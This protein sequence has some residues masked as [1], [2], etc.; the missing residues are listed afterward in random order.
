MSFSS[1]RYGTLDQLFEMELMANGF[2]SA[3]GGNNP[4]SLSYSPE[5]ASLLATG[6]YN[7]TG[8]AR[9]GST[10]LSSAVNGVFHHHQHHHHH[11][12]P[13]SNTASHHSLLTTNN[14]PPT[15]APSPYSPAAA[16]YFTATN[17]GNN[18]N[19]NNSRGM[20]P[21]GSAPSTSAAAAAA[22]NTA[23][24]QMAAVAFEPIPIRQQQQQQ[25]QAASRQQRQ[26]NDHDRNPLEEFLMMGN[27]SFM[28]P[29]SVAPATPAQAPSSN[30]F[31]PL[32]H[33]GGRNGQINNDISDHVQEEDWMRDI[34]LE[35]PSLSLE[36]FSGTEIVRRIKS[37]TGDVIRRYIP[38]VDFLVQC[39]QELRKGLAAAQPKTS[40]RRYRPS[41]V[42]PRQFWQSYIDN[43]PHRFYLTNE[44]RMEQAALQEA[45]QGLQKLRG[46]AKQ[47]VAQGCEAVKN[48]FLGGM[49]EGESWGLRKWLSKNGNALRV[50]TDM[51]CIL[52]SCKELD[53]SKDSTK[54]LAACLRPL[55]KETLDRL[56]KDIPPSYQE[57]ST[58]HPYLPFFHRLEG[59]LRNMS[60]FDPEDDGVICLDDS[61]D[62]DDAPVVVVAP[63]PKRKPA[64]RKRKAPETHTIDTSPSKKRMFEEEAVAKAL[65]ESKQNELIAAAARTAA[66]TPADDGSSSGESDMD[67]VYEIV[68]TLN[69][70]PV[71]IVPQAGTEQLDWRCTNCSVRNPKSAMGICQGCGEPSYNSDLVGTLFSNE[72]DERFGDDLDMN[73]VDRDVDSLPMK[74]KSKK[75]KRKSGG[76]NDVSHRFPIQASYDEM[77]AA[78]GFAQ[79]LAAKVE[80]LATLFD[81]QNSEKP[82]QMV[83]ARKTHSLWDDLYGTALR[84]FS[85]V[86][87]QPDAVHFV[88]PIPTDDLDIINRANN[89][90]RPSYTSVVKNPLCF[91]DI[92]ATLI[93][94]DHM[95][96]EHSGCY[97][98]F[99]GILPR[100]GLSQWNMWRG[101]DLLQAVDL[102]FLNSLAYGKLSGEGRS[103][104][105]S[106]TNDLRKQM[107][108]QIQEVVSNHVSDPE[109]RRHSTPTRRSETSGFVVY[110]GKSK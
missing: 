55:A 7:P 57:R 80:R 86:L 69:H 56:K 63:P 66:T 18:N 82:V 41:T 99:N 76:V 94:L 10:E 33:Y 54:K 14:N 17:G 62:D 79:S 91:S 29:A 70:G 96:Q 37:C 35:V 34:S 58:A 36:P 97:R 43:L 64:A 95:D 3:N 90:D 106:R 73:S 88:E 78:I 98:W 15:T 39:Q 109:Q 4:N 20:S 42:S 68:G 48:S 53:K 49:K 23:L 38:C 71:A 26:Q 65:A 45:V 92:V 105:R 72:F 44:R 84:I 47:A 104:H 81:D 27:N 28:N 22:A 51:E 61:D 11:H 30:S 16:Q 9:S 12:H 52:R 102:V 46:D 108:T 2:A 24:Q 85:E 89:P 75:S 60:Q 13:G 110:K 40:G 74:P 1:N 21:Y 101:L 32:S 8:A 25:Q 93:D 19:F 31:D 87:R 100:R 107:W 83:R 103:R 6:V 67:S 77:N 59:A 5:T 50:C